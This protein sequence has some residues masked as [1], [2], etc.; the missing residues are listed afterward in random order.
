MC[1][2]SLLLAALVSVAS[3]LTYRAADISSL[4][5]VEDSGISYS[6]NGVTKPFEDIL[7][8]NGMTAARVRIWTA[9]QYDLSYGLALGKRIKD[10]GLTLHVDLHY[11]DTCN[12]PYALLSIL[13]D[14]L[15]KGADPGHQAIPSGWPTTLSGLNTQIYECVLFR[16]PTRSSV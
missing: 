4:I 11:S 5:V 2:V 12:N 8:D 10:A 13:T 7:V 16:H 1:T 14:V 15:W 6:Q 9:G 3:A